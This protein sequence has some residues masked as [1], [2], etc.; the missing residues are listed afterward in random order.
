M[1]ETGKIIDNT[2]KYVV[3][4]Q[5]FYPGEYYGAFWSEKAYHGPLLDW[6]AG[7]SHHH[8][9]AGSA[10][11]AMWLEARR[12]NDSEMRRN[13]ELAFD[14][15]AARRHDR[16]GWL[17]I[18]N[19]EKPSNWENT[20][21]DELSTIATAFAIHG[22]GYALLNG[23]PPKKIYMDCLQKAGYWLLGIEWPSGSGIF[24]HHERSP[25]DT[26]N[27]NAHAAESLALIFQCLAKIYGKP[28]N[29]FLQ[30]AK[31]GF[32]HTLPLQWENGCYPYRANNGITINYTSLVAWCFLNL[33]E[34]LPGELT[35]SW[36]EREVINN[37]LNKAS[38]FLCS[39]TKKDGSL[40]W[41]KNETTTAKHNVWTYAITANV[42]TR[43]GGKEN[44]KRAG[45]I[46]NYLS[47]IK[48]GS[49]L[50]PMRDNGEVI[51]ECLFMQADMVVFL[52]D[53][54]N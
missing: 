27:A 30:G 28:I 3:A 49:G 7:G 40:D 6:H 1:S 46:L 10:A 5:E 54:R 2:L 13:A 19:S 38:G 52:K 53:C 48:T 23:L 33:L 32:V 39:C 45:M 26:L 18:Q 35:G 11:L 44:L 17:E 29:I 22:L 4:S 36:L 25:Y 51:T 20:G 24:P 21:L 14:W 16:G 42:L 8:R 43:I 41:E 12:K 37:H 15:L 34:I 47:S 31:R 9:G 50:L